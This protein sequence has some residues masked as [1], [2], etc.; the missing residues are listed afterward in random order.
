MYES[1]TLENVSATAVLT[2][3]RPA[4]LNA[5]TYPMMDEFKHA[6]A[7][8]EQDDTVTGIVITGAG[9]GFCAGM[10]MNALGT[11]SATGEQ[12][13]AESLKE[14]F[15][16]SPGDSSMGED[17]TSGFTYLMTIRKPI[18]AAVNGACAGLGMSIALLCDLRFCADSAKFVTSFSQR[19]LVAEHGQSWILPRV[20]GPS[21]ALDLLW[22]SR[23]VLADE[24]LQIGLVDRIYA[25]DEVLSRAVEYVQ[26]LADSAAPISLQVMKRQIYRHMNMSLGDAMAESTQLMDESLLRDDFKEGVASF[27]EKRAPAFSKIKTD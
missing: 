5:F 19:G 7:T 17:F 9:R 8:A 21:R 4:S 23:R 20:V 16:A 22:S 25:A 27:M 24:A 13:D 11:L 10:D 1:I 14:K 6:L 2:F 26:Q 3:N 18:I 12:K 15:K